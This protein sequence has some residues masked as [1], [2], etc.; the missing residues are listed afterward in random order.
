M[1][2]RD[3]LDSTELLGY[4]LERI[5]DEAHVVGCPDP[6]AERRCGA[7]VP[8]DDALAKQRLEYLDRSAPS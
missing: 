4:R 3:D 5:C 6:D 2:R 1:R 7:E 8:S